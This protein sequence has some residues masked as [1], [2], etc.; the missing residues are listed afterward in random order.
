MSSKDKRKSKQRRD[1]KTGSK[2]GTSAQPTISTDEEPDNLGFL[3][4]IDALETIYDDKHPRRI[5]SV[6][7]TK[8][9]DIARL[10]FPPV[11]A[12]QFKRYPGHI[13]RWPGVEQSEMLEGYPRPEKKFQVASVFFQ[14]KQDNFL[15]VFKDCA[16]YD[17]ADEDYGWSQIGFHHHPGFLSEVDIGGERDL[18]AAP[19]NGSSWMPQVLPEVYN[20]DTKSPSAK[21]TG[22]PGGLCGKLS[23]LIAMAAFSAPVNQAEAIVRQYFGFK[24]WDEHKFPNGRMS[25]TISFESSHF[26]RIVVTRVGLI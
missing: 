23:L 14:A 9:N 16:K 22:Q 7:G 3:Y 10:W 12:K 26:F 24:A 15:A 13:Y 11:R 20:Y 1:H 4:S 18:L 2:S 5:L 6:G 21:S 19:A 8:G 25:H 17:I